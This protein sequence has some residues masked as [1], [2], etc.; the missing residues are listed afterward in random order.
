MSAPT[1]QEIS[2]AIAAAG[3]MKGNSR[4]SPVAQLEDI[5]W[6]WTYNFPHDALWQ[7]WS[8]ENDN[9]P[10]R[11]D[12]DK[13]LS[14]LFAEVTDDHLI[15]RLSSLIEDRLAVAARK[16]AAEYPEAPRAKVEVAA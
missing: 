7:R 12:Y 1:E 3:D 2:D 5:V 6:D 10:G 13:R 9:C 11:P 14:E 15:E 8:C 4:P 16:F